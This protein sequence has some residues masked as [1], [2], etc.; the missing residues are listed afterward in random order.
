MPL[1]VPEIVLVLLLLI[2]LRLLGLPL[3]R[4]RGRAIT[5]RL[6]RGPLGAARLDG[7]MTQ[8]HCSSQNSVYMSISW[9]FLPFGV[10][11]VLLTF[12]FL[13][14]YQPWNLDLHEETESET[15]WQLYG[16]GVEGS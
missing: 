6:G 8:C 15:C 13:P 10:L 4:G 7:L 5:I 3:R 11:T 2:L 9:T 12:K 14:N 16:R 1:G